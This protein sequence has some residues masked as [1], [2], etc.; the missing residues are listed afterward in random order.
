[1]NYLFALAWSLAALLLFLEVTRTWRARRA[2]HWRLKQAQ[3]QQAY[4]IVR[5]YAGGA[6]PPG[7]AFPA[8]E[9]QPVIHEEDVRTAFQHI[10]AAHDAGQL[11]D[12]EMDRLV[13]QLLDAGL[14]VPKDRPVAQV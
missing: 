12:A 10:A 1:M 3:R 6:S 5:Q 7:V 13:N 14:P 9:T 2:R 8:D 11:S 4:A